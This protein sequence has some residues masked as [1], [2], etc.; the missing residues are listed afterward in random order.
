M[1]FQLCVLCASNEQ[2]EW[3][4][5][6]NKMTEK[7]AHITVT[8]LT[9]AYGSFVVMRDLSFTIN[10]GDIFIIM[11]GSGCGK[12]TLLRHMIGLQRPARGDVLYT[13]QSFWQA[14]DEERE[15]LLRRFGVA[16]Q[17]GAMW[18]SMTLAENVGLPL[19]HYTRLSK[20]AIRDAVA[21]R[22]RPIFMSVI[23]SSFG[24]LPLVV[25]PGAG[26]ELYRGLGSVVIGGLVVSTLFT[27]F[28][29]P[30]F[31]SLAMNLAG[32]LRGH[33]QRANGE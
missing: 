7:D 32:W 24:M 26:S 18:S 10:H 8:D 20:E 33:W 3:A 11:G 21:S 12:S 22:V 25:F 31:L 15:A 30:T 6:D 16:Y 1:K 29:V 13:G 5:E 19:R 2:S 23:T 17:G 9:M 28:L 27:L 4:V 14:T